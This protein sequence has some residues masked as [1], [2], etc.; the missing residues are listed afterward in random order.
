VRSLI[1]RREALP[2][3]EDYRLFIED[4]DLEEQFSTWLVIKKQVSKAQAS[5]SEQKRRGRVTNHGK[6]IKRA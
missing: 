1:L 5:K 4:N 3:E 2:S 6:G